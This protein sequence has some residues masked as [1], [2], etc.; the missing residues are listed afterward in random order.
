MAVDAS[1]R[2]A[3]G[4]GHRKYPRTPAWLLGSLH[5]YQLEGLNWMIYNWQHS[6]HVILAD[7]MGKL[8]SLL[9][10]PCPPSSSYFP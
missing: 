6:T 1:S 9:L 7:E 10:R 5:P 4:L 8:S 2:A 3:R